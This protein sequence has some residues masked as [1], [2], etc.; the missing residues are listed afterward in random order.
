MVH[1]SGCL[2][3]FSAPGFGLLV[4]C[5]GDR[6]RSL[7]C[8][9]PL[10]VYAPQTF[11]IQHGVEARNQRPEHRRSTWL[12]A[13]RRL[14]M[15]CPTPPIFDPCS[16]RRNDFR[17]TLLVPAMRRPPFYTFL[18]QYGSGHLPH[19]SCFFSLAIPVGPAATGWRRVLPAAASR[20]VECR[21]RRRR[22]AARLQ[23]S[24]NNSS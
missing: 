1:T 18:L 4:R 16:W 21:C 23:S 3:S 24:L 7:G 14:W 13:A 22:V 17:H 10:Q 12:A 6:P 9:W 19:F 8:R 5:L 2:W 11:N 20:R 15:M